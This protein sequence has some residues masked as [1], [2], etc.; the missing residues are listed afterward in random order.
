MEQAFYLLKDIL[1]PSKHS[2]DRDP[3]EIRDSK[4]STRFLKRDA[5]RR[6]TRHAIGMVRGGV[7]NSNNMLPVLSG[8]AEVEE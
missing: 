8:I 1:S 6:Q 3:A 4:P 2:N 7:Q 5:M